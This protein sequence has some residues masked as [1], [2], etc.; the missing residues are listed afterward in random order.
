M[1]VTQRSATHYFMPVHKT[2]FLHLIK[3][4]PQLFSFPPT[5]RAVLSFL[6]QPPLPTLL[7]FCLDF[8]FLKREGEK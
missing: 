2:L 5:F 7:L 1:R 4:L 3:L 6:N 8:F